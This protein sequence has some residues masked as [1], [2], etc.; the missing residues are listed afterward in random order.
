M[1]L[2]V[3]HPQDEIAF[4][5][6]KQKQGSNQLKRSLPIKREDAQRLIAGDFTPLLNYKEAFAAECYAILNR[7]HYLPKTVV[8]YR[9]KAYVLPENGTGSVENHSGSQIQS[10]PAYLRARH[11]PQ[12][13]P[14]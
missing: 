8:E 2:R 10:L 6:M 13:Q 9:R 3:Y 12:L 5:E 14:E 11:S 1:R 4:L 7:E